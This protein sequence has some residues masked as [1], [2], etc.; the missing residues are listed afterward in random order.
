MRPPGS[1]KF[2]KLQCN[3]RGPVSCRLDYTKRPGNVLY[4]DGILLPHQNAV[5]VLCGRNY[6]G[7]VGAIGTWYSYCTALAMDS[8]SLTSSDLS[9]VRMSPGSDARKSWT[10]KYS[11]S[12]WYLGTTAL[13]GAGWTRGKGRQ[14]IRQF[15]VI[16]LLFKS[17]GGTPFYQYIQFVS[18]LF[19]LHRPHRITL[20][21][22]LGIQVV[23][24]ALV[25][26]LEHVRV[27]FLSKVRANTSSTI[28]KL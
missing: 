5:L 25:I 23:S 12:C 19:C 18:A 22:D 24:N 2:H 7:L 21:D 6:R 15:N 28:V 27:C 8:R 26:G 14:D 10:T 13:Q 20:L 4:S 1:S 11:S 9:N 3:P 16:K 17:L